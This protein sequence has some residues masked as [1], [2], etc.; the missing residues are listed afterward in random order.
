VCSHRREGMKYLGK[1]INDANRS[2]VS[3][4]KEKFCNIE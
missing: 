1:E 2:A 4:L 3:Q